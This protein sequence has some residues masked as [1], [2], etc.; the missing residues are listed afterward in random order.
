MLFNHYYC[1]N[2]DFVASDSGNGDTGLDAQSGLL[3]PH[4]QHQQYLGEHRPELDQFP[5]PEWEGQRLPGKCLY[6]KLNIILYCI[7]I[8][9]ME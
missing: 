4:E 3:A 9:Q 8:V 5:Y 6:F 2:R 1:I 7:G